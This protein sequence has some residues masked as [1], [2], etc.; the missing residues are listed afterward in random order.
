MVALAIV[1]DLDVLEY[2]SLGFCP[3]AINCSNRH[4]LFF[5]D[6]RLQ[7]TV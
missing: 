3:S 1:E 7:V 6:V 5:N 4:T 2:G